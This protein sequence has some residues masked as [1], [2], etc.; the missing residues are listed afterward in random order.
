MTN[1]EFKLIEEKKYFL[2]NLWNLCRLHGG[3]R[4]EN[5]LWKTV[6]SLPKGTSEH[7]SRQNQFMN[8][9]FT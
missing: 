3:G 8:W 2:Y 1:N 7:K 6:W 9:Q 4:K 5:L